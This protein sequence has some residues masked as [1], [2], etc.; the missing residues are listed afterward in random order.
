VTAHRTVTTGA[1]NIRSINI[2]IT[3]KILIKKR[4]EIVE[5]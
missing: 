5:R 3:G 4:G 2:F 1:G